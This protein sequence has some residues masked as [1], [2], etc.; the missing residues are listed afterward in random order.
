MQL[1]IDGYNLI[2]AGRHMPRMNAAGLQRQRDRLID[3]LSSYRKQKGSDITIIFDG[4]QAGWFE[5]QREFKK[6]VEILFTR[7]GEKADDVIK[8]MARYRGSGAVI[9]SSDREIAKYAE[10]M[11]VTVIPSEQFLGRLK[12]SEKRV[13]KDA[14]QEDDE[15]R[16][17]KQKGPS[18]RLSKKEKRLRSVLKK[19]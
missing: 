4:W 6:G 12:I 19:L 2:Y 14:R 13:E 11:G 17:S 18:R 10:K 7:S 1:I 16:R 15:G 5:E 3:L 9:V 8:R